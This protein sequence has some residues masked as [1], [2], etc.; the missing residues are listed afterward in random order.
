MAVPSSGELKLWDDIWNNEI[1]GTQGSNSLHSASVYAGFSTP[2]AMSDFYGWSDIEVPSVTTTD[3]TATCHTRVCAC[4]N[5]TNTGN[6]TSLTRGFYIGTTSNPYSSNTKYTVSGTQSTTGEFK[7]DLTGLTQN[8]RYYAWAWA[9][10]EAGEVVGGRDCVVTPFPPF[11]PTLAPLF[12]GVT[13]VPAKYNGPSAGHSSTGYVNPYSSGYTTL[14]SAHN[15]TPGGGADINYACSTTNALTRWCM[16]NTHYNCDDSWATTMV[17]TSFPYNFSNVSFANSTPG[18][19]SQ[20][21][22]QSGRIINGLYGGFGQ[23]V[24]GRLDYCYS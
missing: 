6:S 15:T 23:P 17:C 16:T 3:I 4:G 19:S 18:G 12:C 22:F 14:T 20:C 2:D 24:T 21:T 8:T 5:I 9:A 7:Y 1:G 11:S 10:N 13:Y